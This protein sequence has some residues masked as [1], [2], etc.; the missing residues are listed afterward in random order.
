MKTYRHILSF[1]L[2][3][4]LALGLATPAFAAETSEILVPGRTAHTSHPGE[5]T[6]ANQYAE[7]DYSNTGDGYIM[8][9][10]L[11]E[12][13]KRVKLRITKD[14]AS[15]TYDM[16]YNQWVSFP[17]TEGSGE[18]KISVCLQKEGTKYT[19]VLDASIKADIDEASAF[20][21][22]NQY[23]DYEGAEQTQIAAWTVT[24]GCETDAERIAAIYKYVAES[25]HYDREKAAAVTAGKMAGYT[26]DLDAVLASEKGICLDYAALTAGM[27]RTV[28]IPCKLIIGNAAG[29]YHAWAAACPRDGSFLPNGLPAGTDE[30]GWVRMDP[31]FM[32]SG[33]E[34]AYRLISNDGNYSAERYY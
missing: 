12:T 29:E 21:Y 1:A 10:F 33:G 26:P 11:E 30:P 5:K 22:S 14:G 28:G 2:L 6:A 27:L 4:T 25:L 19:I 32:S 23:V 13:Q 20:V 17:L 3:F 18:Y 7:I 31:T 15:R 34:G 16:S 24:A 9:R 8:G